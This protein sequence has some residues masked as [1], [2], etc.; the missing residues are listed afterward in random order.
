MKPTLK[1]SAAKRLKLKHH[2]LLSILLQICFRIQLAPPQRGVQEV[3]VQLDQELAVHH[4]HRVAR[5]GEAVQV[6]PIIHS[7]S[8]WN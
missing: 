3:A 1:A 8:A 6:D 4:A 5:E 2:K 7:E